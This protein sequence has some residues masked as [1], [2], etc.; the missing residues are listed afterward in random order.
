MLSD[1]RALGIA[2][3]GKADGFPVLW[4]PGTPGGRRQIPPLARTL[5]ATRDVRLIALERP[6]I[7][8]ST[9]HAYRSLIEWADDVAAIADQ[10]GVDRFGLVGLSGGGPYVLAC[11]HQLPARVVA[12]AVL[13]GVAPSCGP[14]APPGGAVGF[15][16]RFSVALRILHVPLGLAVWAGVYAL[17][18]LASQVFDLF[19]TTMPEGDQAVFRRPEMKEMFLDDMLRAGR[20]RLRSPVSDLVL[21]TQP[22]GF[23]VCD[24][25]VPIH[26][27]HGDADT[28]VPLEHAQHLSSLVP[29]ATLT[30]RSRE[31]HLGSLDAVGEIFEAIL[32]R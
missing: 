11:A 24:I 16:A 9:P 14:D 19:L 21:F 27:W 7:G 28:F 30:V 20:S 17:R 5:A 31:G 22:W 1:R 23:S 4:F 3:Y 6:G 2:E 12:A 26:F 18:P 25:T 15:A 29:D 13:G 8:D 32:G 10:L